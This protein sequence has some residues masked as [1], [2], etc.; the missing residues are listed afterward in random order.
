M[1]LNIAFIQLRLLDII[2]ILLVASLL[3]YLFRLVKGTGAINIMLGILSIYV[4]WFV[5]RTFEMELLTEIL[6]QFVSVGV[7]AL[8]IVFQPEI[9]KFLQMIGRRSI[10]NKGPQ[11][12]WR[13]LWQIDNEVSLNYSPVVKACEIMSENRTGALIVITKENSLDY[14]LE[15]GEPLDAKISDQLIQNI[16]Y[17]NS[18]LHDGAIIISQNR[19]KA[20][21]CV[22]PVSE[23]NNLPANLGLRHRAALG[24]TE[25]SDAI[26]II[27]SEQTGKIS[28]C[29]NA[30]IKKNLTP[31]QLREFLAKEFAAYKEVITK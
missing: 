24:I 8:I 18:P 5:V 26:A 25:Q 7:L 31:L 3:F 29:K 9:R 1:L 2:D 28:L 4:I 12:A 11:S 22:L 16:F 14:F 27:V 10:I 30:E 20:A 13:R 23:N 21:R 17:K 15:S 6:G 19:I